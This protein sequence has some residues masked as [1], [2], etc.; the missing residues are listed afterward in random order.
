[1]KVLAT[2]TSGF[3]G[4][5]VLRALVRHGIPVVCVGRNRPPGD[6][7][8]IQADLLSATDLTSVVAK[9]GATHLLHLAW[10]AEHGKYWTSPLNLRWV[11]AT[12]RLVEA[13]CAAG[14]QQVVAAG[15]CAEYDWSYG[16]CREEVTPAN[17]ATLYGTA[18]DAA[19]RLV[20]A[21][22]AARQVPCAW[23]RIFLPYGPGEVPTRLIP[24]LTAVFRGQAAPFGVNAAAFRDFLHVDDLAEAFV[25]L[26]QGSADG[27]FNISS[28]RPVAV[29][30]LVRTLAALMEAD[31]EPVLRLATARPSEPPLLVGD[32]LR[33]Q[34]HGWKPLI[35][36]PDGLKQL[37]GGMSRWSINAPS[38]TA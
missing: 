5:P 30:D 17:P 21:I 14:G 16:Y 28:G 29:A 11:D 3:V 36:L 6:V 37:L 8:F 9:A 35:S 19:R 4:Q 12:V 20:T 38:A 34:A 1:M 25:T 32:S 31:P 13:F 26:L 7:D 22:C 10:Y 18:K 27:I 33:L 24:S 15:T 2:G 23:G